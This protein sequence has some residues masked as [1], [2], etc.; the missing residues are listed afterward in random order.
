MTASDSFRLLE[1]LDLRPLEGRY[2]EWPPVAGAGSGYPENVQ[3]TI[4]ICTPKSF[5]LKVFIAIPTR[6]AVM[7]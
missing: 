5:F 1:D 6:S 3:T 2:S 4:L 7:L